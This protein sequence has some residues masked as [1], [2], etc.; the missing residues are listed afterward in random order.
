MH[1][2]IDDQRLRWF[3]SGTEMPACYLVGGRHVSKLK[4]QLQQAAFHADK[5][6]TGERAGPSTHQR[7]RRPRGAH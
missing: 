6:L 1:L 2:L 7:V 3:Q 4:L 5:I